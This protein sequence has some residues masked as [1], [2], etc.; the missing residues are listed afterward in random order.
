M[1]NMPTT[2]PEQ[3]QRRIAA[4]KLI[5]GLILLAIGILTFADFTGMIDYGQIWRFWPMLLICAGI[6]HEIDA[7]RE[8]RSTGGFILMAVGTWLLVSQNHIFGLH[9][10]SAF[11]LALT[12]VGLGII[13]HALVDLPGARKERKRDRC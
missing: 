8:R 7:L 6:A 3:P 4:G 5:F 2:P 1:D 9:Y 12:V 11:P 10:R 13:V